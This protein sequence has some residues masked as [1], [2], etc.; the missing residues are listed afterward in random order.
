MDTGSTDRIKELYQLIIDGDEENRAADVAKK[1]IKAGANP[2]DIIEQ[3]VTQAMRVV[4]QRFECLEIFLP[5][6]VRSADVVQSALEVIKPFL[7]SKS[8]EEKKEAVILGTIQGDIHDF[9]KNIVRTLLVAN[10]VQVIDLGK[11]VHGRA[12]IEA[13]RKHNS[14]MLAISILMSTSL[15][16][17]ADLLELLRQEEIRDQFKVVVG[18]GCTSKEWANKVGADAYGGTAQDAVKIIKTWEVESASVR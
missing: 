3:G 12:F 17:A 5:E 18:G 14:R 6:M 7:I 10:G 9:G 11:D 13:A 8:G 1:A 4:G 2:L 15:A 16:F